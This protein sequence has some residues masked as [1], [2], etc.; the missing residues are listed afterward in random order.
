M[1]TWCTNVGNR[2]DELALIRIRLLPVA[3][4]CASIICISG[5]CFVLVQSDGTISWQVALFLGD[6]GDRLRSIVRWRG[7]A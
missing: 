1:E 7:T 5:G 3:C 4:T 2:C 6:G